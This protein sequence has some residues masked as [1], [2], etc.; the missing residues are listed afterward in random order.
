M[1]ESVQIVCPHCNVTNRIPT[2]KMEQAAKCGRCKRPLFEGQ[3]LDLTRSNFRKH[4]D[5]TDIPVVVD[6]WAPWCGPCRMM[7][8]IFAQAAQQVEPYVRLAKVNSELEQEIAADFGIR[9][10]PTLVILK[11]GKEI[12]RQ[13]GAMQLDQLLSWIRRNV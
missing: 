8:P 5:Q 13:A 10:I 12:S 11:S 1:A 2:A 7:A 3:P 4:V 6:F 9:S